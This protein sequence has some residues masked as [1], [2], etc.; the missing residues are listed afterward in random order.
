MILVL[1]AGL[2]ESALLHAADSDIP[3]SNPLG[4]KLNKKPKLPELHHV[5]DVPLLK[6]MHPPESMTLGEKNELVCGTCHGI[7]KIADLPHE[8]VDKQANNF[9]RG[10][11]YAQLTDFCYRCHDQKR[12]ERPNIH[13]MLDQQGKINE[14]HCRYCHEEPLKRDRVYQPGQLKLRM[15]REKLCFGCHLKTPHLNALEHQAKPSKEVLKQLQASEQKLGLILPL[16][17]DGKL[18]CVTCHSPHPPGVLNDNLAAA[19]QVNNSD[20]K[21]GISY[22][23]HPWSDVYAEDKRDRLA[24]LERQMGTLQTL[25]Y[26]RIHTEVLL[27]LPAKDGTLCQACHTFNDRE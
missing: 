25:D 2:F 7:E 22:I 16:S 10:G 27:R 11:P 8:K 18:M 12:Q 23:E 17:E 24:Q 1:L 9:L 3:V 14:D 6:G 26:Q 13:V 21:T 4:Q 19:K 5:V 20:L 15:P